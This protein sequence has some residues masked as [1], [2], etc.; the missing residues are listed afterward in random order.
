MTIETAASQRPVDWKPTACILCECNCGI[1][2][3]LGG[4]DGR[5]L[6]QIR[7]DKAHPASL[8]YTCPKGRSL[9]QLHHHP[10][11]IFQPLMKR[12]G[13]F[14]PASW[15]ETL[16]DIAGRD[17]VRDIL[18]MPI[19]TDFF[20]PAPE[21]RVRGRIGFSARLDDPRKNIGLLLEALSRLDDRLL[22]D[23]GLT[24]GAQSLECSKL[25]W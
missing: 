24:R 11:G 15:D 7:G 21:R 19:D 18:P 13:A 20:L 22:A 5:R 6:E 16:D 10:Q 9:G 14:V 25:F 8:G 1:L 23:I 4:P 12:D 17:V 3:Q 2:V